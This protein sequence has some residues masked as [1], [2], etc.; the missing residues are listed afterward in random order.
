MKTPVD[1]TTYSALASPRDV[2]GNFLLEDG[3]G[4]SI[5]DRCPILSLDSAIDFVMGGIILE[6]VDHVFEVN[7]K[8]SLVVTI[9]TLP[10]LKLK[11]A[12]VARCPIW[13]Y[14]FILTFTIMS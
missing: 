10:E 5:D 2:G 1:S 6:H 8:G 11:A 12:L 9:S 7:E 3:D 14:P 13:P 4:L